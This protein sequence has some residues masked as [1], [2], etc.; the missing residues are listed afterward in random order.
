MFALFLV[1]ACKREDAISVNPEF[2]GSWK[3]F[4]G[5][6]DFHCLIIPKE[7]SGF[8]EYYENNKFHNDTQSR[9]WF[10][11]NGYLLFGRMSAGEER[12]RIDQGPTLS[13]SDF[14]SSYDTVNIGDRYLILN[15]VVYVD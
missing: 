2:A 1:S 13:T 9:K 8:I 4:E 14:I 7:G 5:E 10:V 6:S 11:K 3:H 12:F 15:G